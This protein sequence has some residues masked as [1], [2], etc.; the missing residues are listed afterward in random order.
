MII[1]G[2]LLRALDELLDLEHAAG[3]A[4]SKELVASPGFRSHSGGGGLSLGEEQSKVMS[5]P[6][7]RWFKSAR[8]RR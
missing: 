7:G 1:R 4:T 8:Q 5:V 2:N 3:S 6:S